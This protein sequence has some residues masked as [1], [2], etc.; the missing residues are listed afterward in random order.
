ML[1]AL[2]HNRRAQ[3]SRVTLLAAL[4]LFAGLFGDARALAQQAEASS[5]I[6]LRV[7]V[8]TYYGELN[9]R[10]FPA[11]PEL[12]D[13][14]D[15]LDYLTWGVDAE[16]Y[17][18]NGWGVGLQYAN[19]QFS[20]SDRAIDWGGDLDASADDFG[21]ALNVSTSINDLAAY[22]IWSANDGRL[23]S[24]TAVLAPFVKLGFGVTRFQ[25]RGDLFTLGGR[26]YIYGDD[27][28]VFA[29]PE[30]FE[31]PLLLPG[32]VDGEYET[33]LRD[34]RTNGPSAY[35]RYAF[36]V[37]GGIG[38][39]VRLSEDFSLQLETSARF[40]T[41][42]N[43]DDVSGPFQTSGGELTQYASNPSGRGGFTRGE[44]GNDAYAVTTL[45]ARFY[46][47][48]RAEGFRTPFI[49]LGDLPLGRTDTAEQATSRLFRFEPIEP[50]PRD[51]ARL[52]ALV[53]RP[54]R[55]L[56]VARP[57]DR[58]PR[59]VAPADDAPAIEDLAA[60][61]YTPPAFDTAAF[62]G[63]TEPGA[64]D[65]ASRPPAAVVSTFP[66]SVSDTA[67][68]IDPALSLAVDSLSAVQP[69]DSVATE[70]PFAAIIDTADLLDVI[71][72]PAAADSALL[73]RLD[74]LDAA[75]AAR[76]DSIGALLAAR[77]AAID[78]V[79]QLVVDSTEIDSS[80]LEVMRGRLDSL[81]RLRAGDERRLQD[82]ERQRR[83]AVE[84]LVADEPR[85][86]SEPSSRSSRS[87][88]AR[89]ESSREADP[90]RAE[91]DELRAD[92]AELR[93][94]LAQL[95][96]LLAAERGA[97]P[98]A[99]TNPPPPLPSAAPTAVPAPAATIDSALLAEIRE[100]RAAVTALRTAAVVAPAT[101]PAP[102]APAAAGVSEPQRA[103][104]AAASDPRVAVVEA[105]VGQPVRRVF[106]DNAS[107]E[108]STAGLA[109][110]Q[111]VAA[112]A[113]AHPLYAVVS[114]EGFTSRTGSQAFN[115]AL[116]ERRVRAVRRALEA[117]GV[118]PSQIE[119]RAQG[120]DFDAADPALGRRVEV[121]VRLR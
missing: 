21:R 65:T 62:G 25:P 66:A 95:T 7:G 102:A 29:A 106:F 22:A 16:R 35:G 75:A 17:F 51:S 92:Q 107:A 50:L 28:R 3:V 83:A 99:S 26:R 69:L 18:G 84:R 79:R 13:L 68:S 104:P 44:D 115:A 82:L 8:A 100:L 93:R 12:R 114:L 109:I 19:A 78:S 34:L 61:D 41:T 36:H 52:D 30:G 80:E 39:N 89:P 111:E 60:P 86:R 2:Q 105:L 91:I 59:V 58:T 120:E 112:L 32:G 117:L 14:G 71:S 24:E 96:A 98:P 108:V 76:R 87:R 37:L 64:V 73:V 1:S 10:L 45:T 70:L 81:Q 103:R 43:L 53:F 94:Q 4:F 118:A 121:R 20:A 113:S 49:V 31:A 56:A 46:F 15:N 6:G 57:R 63:V 42:D 67:L 72:E 55:A 116:S 27:G 33:D 74:S 11:R 97:A 47:G 90:S 9:D 23:L 5:S 88:P 38:L 77:A 48:D 85:R 101:A 54:Q 110:L 40:T 119:L